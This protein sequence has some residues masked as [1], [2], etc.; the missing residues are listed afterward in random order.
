MEMYVNHLL[1][2]QLH[3]RVLLMENA[4]EI[5][6]TVTDSGVTWGGSGLRVSIVNVS[7]RNAVR[8][9][10]AWRYKQPTNC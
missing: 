6:S 7:D 8:L 3:L 2:H 10:M 5:Y 9:V 4:S 1:R